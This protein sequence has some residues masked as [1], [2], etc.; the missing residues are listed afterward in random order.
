[1]TFGCTLKL[2]CK[3][4]EACQA[5]G[6]RDGGYAKVEIKARCATNFE[7]V[8]LIDRTNFM[9]IAFQRQWRKKKAI[10]SKKKCFF[11]FFFKY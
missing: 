6:R 3:L 2:G 5:A 1:M 8:N 9:R 7:E 4:D 10:S 11:F